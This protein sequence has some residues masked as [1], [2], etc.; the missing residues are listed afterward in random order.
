M[1]TIERFWLQLPYRHAVAAALL[2]LLVLVAVLSLWRWGDG[3][4]VQHQQLS[5]AYTELQQITQQ[6]Q[7]QTQPAQLTGEAL[8]SRLLGHAV[9]PVLTGK[10]TDLRAVDGQVMAQVQQAPAQ[11]LFD[12]LAQLSAQGAVIAQFQLSRDLDGVVSGRLV[13][14]DAS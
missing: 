12:W 11:A 10:I 7:G 5:Q 3:V 9:P 8:R 13:W 4:R 6:M 1:K 2:G 14:G